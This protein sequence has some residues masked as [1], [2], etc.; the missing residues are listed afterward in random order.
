MRWLLL[1][2]LLLTACA[3]SEKRLCCVCKGASETS[4]D[5]AFQIWCPT[6]E[7]SSSYIPRR[8]GCREGGISPPIR[9][10][11]VP[12]GATRL[13]I[14]VEDA[15]CTYAC[16]ACCKFQ[17]WALDFPLEALTELLEDAAHTPSIQKLTLPNST[18]KRVYTPFCPPPSQTHAYTL[19]AIAYRR[20]GNHIEIL[21]RSQSTPLLFKLQ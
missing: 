10:K 6:Q 15:T 3:S 17:H 19:Q 16:N 11:G 20:Q 5:P 12:E 2:S 1:F 18:G 9:W 7:E 4:Y 13:R 8:Y 14:F 21:G